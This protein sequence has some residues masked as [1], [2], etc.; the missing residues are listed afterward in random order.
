MLNRS[1]TMQ[2]SL[3]DWD[4]MID[5]WAGDQ[6]EKEEEKECWCVKEE[7]EDNWRWHSDGG[8]EM[9]QCK[10]RRTFET[11]EFTVEWQQDTKMSSAAST[12]DDDDES[13]P[14]L[15]MTFQSI[16]T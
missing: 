8:M 1:G 12:T 15:S 4:K 7:Q 16:L 3:V 11:T 2:K 13:H 14:S 9:Q 6:E 5:E 10:R